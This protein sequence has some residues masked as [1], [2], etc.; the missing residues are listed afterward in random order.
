MAATY[1]IVDIRYR[2]QGGDTFSDTGLTVQRINGPTTLVKYAELCRNSW[3]R[4]LRS[5]TSVSFSLFS[6]QASVAGDEYADFQSNAGTS[7]S[8][9]ATTGVC[10]LVSKIPSQGPPGRFYFP[11]IGE[12][13]VLPSGRLTPNAFS[14]I[15]QDFNDFYDDLVN[16]SG[17]LPL[18]RRPDGTFDPITGFKLKPYVGRQDR[19]LQRSRAS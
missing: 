14:N 10:F 6:T 5:T 7:Q 15:S 1:G 12:Q 4:T 17:M 11:G 9:G 16:I 18:I 3:K 8:D 13:L 2:L 19:R